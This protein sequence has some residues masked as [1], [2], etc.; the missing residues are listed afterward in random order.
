MITDPQ[1]ALV[2]S[3]TYR[4][5]VHRATYY[6]LVFQIAAVVA[7]L[8]IF[9]LFFSYV[10]ITLL[11]MAL[12]II[13]LSRFRRLPPSPPLNIDEEAIVRALLTQHRASFQRGVYLLRLDPREIPK[14]TLPLFN[15]AARV[16]PLL[17]AAMND[18]LPQNWVVQRNYQLHIAGR[19]EALAQQ[20]LFN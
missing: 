11:T 10:S 15:N 19:F 17:I 12:P 3:S 20:I 1:A 13:A 5:A 14:K 6:A 8:S 2:A 9:G 7:V 4:A 16:P 18:Y